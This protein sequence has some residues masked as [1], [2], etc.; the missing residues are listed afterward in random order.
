MPQDER[1]EEMALTEKEKHLKLVFA[2]ITS[3]ISLKLHNTTENN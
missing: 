2:I 3:E 1:I